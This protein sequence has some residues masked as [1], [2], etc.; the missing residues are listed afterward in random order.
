MDVWS[1]HYTWDWSRTC[2]LPNTA[3]W[4]NDPAWVKRTLGVS[5]QE[6]NKPLFISEFYNV[7]TTAKSPSTTVLL[8]PADKDTPLEEK[9][10]LH[11][12]ALRYVAEGGRYAGLADIGPFCL[13]PHF[14]SFCATGVV[15]DWPAGDGSGVKPTHLGALM[16]NPGWSPAPAFAWSGRH[17]DVKFAFHP[18]YAFSKEYS[19]TFWSGETIKRT[20]V[21]FN[22]ERRPLPKKLRWQVKFGDTVAAEGQRDIATKIGYYD[23]FPIEFTVPTVENRTEGTLELAVDVDGSEAF[24]NSLPLTVFPKTLTPIVGGENAKIGFFHLSADQHK[25]LQALNI[26]GTDIASG[27][28]LAGVKVVLVG[29][30]G[31]ATATDR[32]FYE[33]LAKFVAAGGC[34]IAFEQT[35]SWWL[36]GNLPIAEDSWSTI[37]FKNMEHPAVAGLT[38][39]DL[40]FWGA[41]NTISRGN[42]LLK[43]LPSERI[44]ALVVEGSA[45]GLAY[46]S[47]LEYRYGSGAYLLCQMP[48]LSKGATEAAAGVLLRNLASY[49][50]G[51][52]CNTPAPAEPFTYRKFWRHDIP[53]TDAQP[54]GVGAVACFARRKQK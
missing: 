8:G 49:A 36:P 42:F 52:T 10:N 40:R 38:D 33:A 16:V 31:D 35:N 14:W 43:E 18:M 41:D 47:L 1:G 6:L 11:F 46:T 3:Y 25:T 19:H 54:A 34:V 29:N 7:D 23:E 28:D 24:R 20:L 45:M 39:G 9:R 44:N 27:A 5:R 21:C 50:K 15:M 30:E 2:Q 53:L 12:R 51:Y 48:V 22:D 26:E 32:T 17:E 13:V 4:Y 37:G